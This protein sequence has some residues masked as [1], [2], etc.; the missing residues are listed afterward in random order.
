MQYSIVTSVF[1]R[2][3][4]AQMLTLAA[5]LSSRENYTSSDESTM[6][7]LCE[8]DF[9]LPLLWRLVPS[10]IYYHLSQSCAGVIMD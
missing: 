7:C 9:H 4:F 2:A 6:S 3:S 5:A 8:Q 10:A 1:T